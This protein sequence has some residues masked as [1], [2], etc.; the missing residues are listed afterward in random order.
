MNYAGTEETMKDADI[1]K[2]GRIEIIDA[3]F[4]QRYLAG[5]KIPYDIA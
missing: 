2:N 3:A 5:I 1:D 4:V